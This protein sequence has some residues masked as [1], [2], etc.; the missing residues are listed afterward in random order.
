[1]QCLFVTN[2]NMICTYLLCTILMFLRLEKILRFL[3]QEKRST[4]NLGDDQ[5]VKDLTIQSTLN[6]F[7]TV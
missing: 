4:Q 3:K 6:Q 2:C 5:I 1:M 7:C